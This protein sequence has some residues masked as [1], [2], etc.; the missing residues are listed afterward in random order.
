MADNP[1]RHLVNI[2]HALQA[3]ELDTGN[4]WFDPSNLEITD[5]TVGNPATNVIPAHAEARLNI[6]FND[7]HTGAELVQWIETVAAR[8][9]AGASVEA[10]ISGEAFLTEP[11]EFSALLADA[12]RAEAGIETEFSTSGGTSDA[13]FI[14]RLCPV[15][16]FG[17]PGQSMHKT[18]EHVAVDDLHALT[19]IYGRIL[20]AYFT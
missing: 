8:E 10:K 12:I 14:R 18:D 3:R 17:L 15:V 9:T 16:E 7:E 20:Q 1:V 2:L 13:R 4:A 19:R 11:G 6:R 5:M